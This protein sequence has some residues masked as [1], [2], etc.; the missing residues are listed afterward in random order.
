MIQNTQD[1]PF[2]SEKQSNSLNKHETSSSIEKPKRENKIKEEHQINNSPQPSNPPSQPS[3]V[4]QLSPNPEVSSFQRDL[5]QNI[6]NESL[7][8]FKN[9]MHFKIQNLQVE[10][11]KLFHYQKEEMKDLLISFKSVSE[12]QEENKR[13]REENERLKKMY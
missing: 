12:L 9:E 1:T 8:D 2:C 10:M 4:V 7:D 3:S 13:L 11:L 5:M 6:I